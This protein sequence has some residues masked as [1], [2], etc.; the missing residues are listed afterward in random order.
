MATS[1]GQRPT[2]GV[3]VAARP[4]AGLIASSAPIVPVTVA[5]PG[6][7]PRQWVQI[8][9]GAG[10]AAMQIQAGGDYRADVTY[11]AQEAALILNADAVTEAIGGYLESS[12]EGVMALTSA[13]D[14]QPVMTIA[15]QAEMP[16][17]ASSVSSG[18]VKVYPMGMDKSGTQVTSS[19]STSTS[20]NTITGWV[21]TPDYAAWTTIVDNQLVVAETGTVTI[22][23]TATIS[24]AGTTSHSRGIHL[25]IDGTNVATDSTTVGSQ[26]AFNAT[27][28]GVVTVGQK[29]GMAAWVQATTAGYRNLTAAQ[30]VAM[31]PS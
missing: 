30:I 24:T 17:E 10:E 21:P 16:I 11:P 18:D 8:P 15:G 6:S 27:Y 12:G 14:V 22:T 2:V 20:A 23:V 5:P 25:R 7:V 19:N 13:S 26:T 28:T 31:P 3:S 9:V 29:I 4:S 1:V